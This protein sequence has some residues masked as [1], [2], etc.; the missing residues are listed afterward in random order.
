MFK[1]TI[2]RSIQIVIITLFCLNVAAATATA[3]ESVNVYSARIEKLI[4][5]AFDAFTKKTGI[6]VKYLTAKEAILLERLKAEGKYTD[7]DVLITVDAGNLWLASREGVLQPVTSSRLER[8]VPASLRSPDG[9]WFGLTVRART[10]VYSLERV[11]PDELS[12]YEDL[13]NP[14][15][16]GR[17]C[18]RTSKKV[19]N[20][21]M[22]ATMIRSLG[23]DRAT[24][25]VSGWM[26][27]QPRIYPKDSSLLKG[28]AAGKCDVGIVNTYY[29]GR[30][31]A[32]KPGFPVGLFWA[33]QSDRG[34]HVN[35]SG[36]GVTRY[37]RNKENAIK[38]IEFLSSEEAQNLF[39][40]NN[41]EYPVNP[42]VKPSSRLTDWW[43]QTFKADRVNVAAAGEHQKAAVKLMAKAGYR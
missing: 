17:L 39:A 14:K 30:E 28:I 29:L 33:N 1:S 38:L 20:K 37:A 26:K 2:V 5:P 7:A 10:I 19:Y 11:S 21:S 40:D 25:V 24:K 13:G 27:N 36:A 16:Q 18:L 23:E 8:Q 41:M 9:S 35:I 34:V 3:Q 6:Q 31:L 42:E 32:K 4:K 15:W 12:T 43:G 22:V